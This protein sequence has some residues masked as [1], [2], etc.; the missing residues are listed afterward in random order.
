MKKTIFLFLGFFLFL[1]CSKKKLDLSERVVDSIPVYLSLANED[2]VQYESRLRYNKKAFSI[3][4][5]Q[6]NDSLNRVNLFKVANRYFNMNNIEEYQKTVQIIL[7]KSKSSKDTLSIAKAYSYLGDY[8]TNTARKDS[9]YSY[10]TRAEKIYQKLNDKD[11]LA[12]IYI[13]IA[14]IQSYEN[15]FSRSEFSAIKALNLLRDNGNINKIYDVYGQLGFISTE[16]KDYEKALEYHKKTLN[17]ALKNNLNDPLQKISALNNIGNVYQRQNKDRLAIQKFQEGLKDIELINNKSYLHAILLD[18]LAYSKFKIKDFS[19][20]PDLFNE[21]LKIRDSLNMGV[22]IVFVKIHLSEYYFEQKDTIKAGRFAREAL[23]LSKKI[24]NYRAVLASLNQLSNVEPSKA[25]I[26][27]EEYIQLSDSLHLEERKMQNKFARI[28]FETDEIISEK[29]KAVDQKWTILWIAIAITLAGLLFY[30]FKM[31]Q[32]KKRELLLLQSR[33]RADHEIYQ[34]ML[35]QQEKFDQGRE[36]EK[37]RMARE[38]HDRVMDRLKSIR[39]NLFVL[40]NH[41]DPKTIAHCI[42]QVSQIQEVEKEVRDIAHDLSYDAFSLKNDY[43]ELL[44]ALAKEFADETALKIDLKLSD[45]IDW[46]TLSAVVKISI[47]RILQECLQDIK[48]HINATEAAISI[49]EK[50]GGMLIEIQDNDGEADSNVRLAGLE[51][52]NSRSRLEEMNGN[53]EIVS[54][55]S[56]TSIKITIPT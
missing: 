24:K 19:G 42:Q 49:S 35:E 11:N 34:L 10:Y 39:S 47:Y 5:N 26:Y 15:D 4:I 37:K 41:T 21:S 18:N 32:S 45:A 17:L 53:L 54:S 23:E 7:E 9:A 12:S 29:D 40:Q 33:Q 13:N 52:S 43:A 56:G 46:E 8:Y 3:F 48:K 51:N 20:L 36:K 6:E 30:T 1:A 31:Q 44:K 55:S 38:L 27:R 28:E 22:G 50:R 16:L 14:N 2:S 25:S